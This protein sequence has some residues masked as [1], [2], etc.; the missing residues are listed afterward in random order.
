MLRKILIITMHMGI[1]SKIYISVCLSTVESKVEKQVLIDK[2]YSFNYL[3][4][5]YNSC[6]YT[7]LLSYFDWYLDTPINECLKNEDCNNSNLICCE[8]LGC[9]GILK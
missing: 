8:N 5:I 1:L 3:N 7:S 9:T 4:S 6:S 2:E